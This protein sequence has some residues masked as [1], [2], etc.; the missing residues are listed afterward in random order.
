[1]VLL[2]T[3]WLAGQMQIM[4]HALTRGGLLVSGCLRAWEVLSRGP[5]RCS[6]PWLLPLLRRNICVCPMRH[7]RLSGCASLS[8]SCCTSTSTRCSRPRSWRTIAPHKNGAT[9]PLNHAK[10]KH[11]DVAYHFV[12]EQCTEFNALK[13]T[14]MDTDSMLADIGTKALPEPRYQRLIRSIM[15][16]KDPSLRSPSPQQTSRTDEIATT[17]TS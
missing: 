15:N 6:A 10:Q 14:P 7:T 4:L 9:T 13:V 11:I 1:M 8:R 12:R 3:L 2:T 17:T 16:I 5:L